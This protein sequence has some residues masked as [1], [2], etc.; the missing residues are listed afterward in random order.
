MGYRQ[1]TI[2]VNRG[3]NNTILVV[4]HIELIEEGILKYGS[5]EK[6][7]LLYKCSIL[8][9]YILLKNLRGL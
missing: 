7:S 1:T 2:V 8:L 5:E 3:K 9:G 4:F 6:G